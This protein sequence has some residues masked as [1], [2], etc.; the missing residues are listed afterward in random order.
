MARA[1]RG[2]ASEY[3]DEAAKLILTT[4]R[5]LATVARELGIYK[6]TTG[7]RLTVFDARNDTG[8]TD[9]REFDRAELLRLQQ[10]N[11]DMKLWHSRRIGYRHSTPRGWQRQVRREGDRLERVGAAQPQRERHGVAASVTV[12]S[13]SVPLVLS[14]TGLLTG[15]PRVTGCTSLQLAAIGT[16]TS[17]SDKA[18]LFDGRLGVPRYAAIIATRTAGTLTE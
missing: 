5:A 12:S 15:I 9:V 7:R 18:I 6:A 3:K 2:F 8:E 11:A 10:E 13:G 17:L 16:A 14:L 1:R 4:G